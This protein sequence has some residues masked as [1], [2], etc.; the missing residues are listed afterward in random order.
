MGDDAILSQFLHS[1]FKII[2]RAYQKEIYGVATRKSEDSK[3][4]LEAINVAISSFLDR[5]KYNS[6]LTDEI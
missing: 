5:K 4:L 6:V 2:N 1:E 3:E